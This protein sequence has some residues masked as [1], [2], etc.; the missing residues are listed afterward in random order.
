[1]MMYEEYR[2]I[3]PTHAELEQVLQRS[4]QGD[5]RVRRRALTAAVAA[6]CL[7]GF[8]VPAGR[9]AI[10][11]GFDS[12]N[13][14]M[15][16]G[17]APGEAINDKTAGAHSTLGWSNIEPGTARVLATTADGEQLVAVGSIEN[18]DRYACFDYGHHYGDCSPVSGAAD[19]FAKSPI[20]HAIGTLSHTPGTNVMWALTSDQVTE[21]E[22]RFADG[23]SQKQAVHNGVAMLFDPSRKATTLVAIGADGTELGSIDVRNQNLG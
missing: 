11:G 19:L 15:R 20:A 6:M 7:A 21:V 16:G 8:V 10:S 5:H 18:G 17:T 2:Q 3:E 12:L 9:A 22:L 13:A 23:T 1:M 14:F 4:R